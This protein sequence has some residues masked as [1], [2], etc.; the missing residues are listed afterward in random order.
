MRRILFLLIELLRELG[1]ENAYRRHLAVHGR[2]HSP[3]E[4]RRFLDARLRS[5]YRQAKCC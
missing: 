5:R 1:D 3:G 4:W 2:V